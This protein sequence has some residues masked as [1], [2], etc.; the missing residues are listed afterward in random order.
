MSLDCFSSRHLRSLA[1]KVVGIA[2]QELSFF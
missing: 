1:Q 2:E